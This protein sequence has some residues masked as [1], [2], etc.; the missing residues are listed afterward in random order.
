MAA[1]AGRRHDGDFFTYF[2]CVFLALY[3]LPSS[4]LAIENLI[5]TTKADLDIGVHLEQ[6]WS[7][8]GANSIL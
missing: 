1:L 7:W 3:R 6:D 5:Q 2:V 8:P 4:D